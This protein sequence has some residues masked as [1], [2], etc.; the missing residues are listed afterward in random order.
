MLRTPK[1]DVHPT[2]KLNPNVDSIFNYTFD[3]IIIEGYTDDDCHPAIK[4]PN[5]AV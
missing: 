4:F 5:A 2:V 3:D 1:L